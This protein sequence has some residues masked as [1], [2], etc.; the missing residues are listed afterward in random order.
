[1]C[2]QRAA[3]ARAGSVALLASAVMVNE[4][5]PA[6]VGLRCAIGRLSA[7]S[8]WGRRTLDP[9]EILLNQDAFWHDSRCGK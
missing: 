9:R 7:R 8:A 1:M 3:I 2:P 5:N 4:A 6:A